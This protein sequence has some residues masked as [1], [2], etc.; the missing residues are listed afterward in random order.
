MTETVALVVA[1]GRGERIGGDVPKQYLALA[2]R[3][4]LVHSVAAFAGHRAVGAVRVVIHPDDRARYHA[5][6]AGFDLLE[7]VDGG[8]TRQESVLFGLESLESLAPGRVL[9]HDAA[10]PAVD[11]GVIDRVLA[12]LDSAP[13]AIPALAVSDTLKRGENGLVAATV[14]RAGL[15]RAQTP[16]G[17][18]YADIL[19]AHRAAAGGALTDDAAVAEAAGLAVSLVAG[20]EDNVKVTTADDL[21]RAGRIVGAGLESRVGMGFDVHR[22][23]PGDHVMLCGVRIGHDRG[24]AGHSDADAG[25]HALVDAVLGAL[26]AGDIGAHFPPGDPEWADADSGVFAARTARMVG[27]AGGVIAHLDVTI[28]CEQPRVGPHR[29]AM[30]AR[31]AELFGVD[32][33]RVSVKATTTERLGFLG[34]GEGV[35]ALAVATLRLPA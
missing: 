13:A 22:F 4:L 20:S 30:A 1:A 33:G 8:A 17:F 14:D 27:D 9:I 35:A 10:R 6:V 26:G 25:L 21:A 11:G 7:P 23:G 16:Q 28:A 31:V 29:T 19:A 32:A 18:R 34:R 2:G 24:L 5:A 3:P 12:A 15:W